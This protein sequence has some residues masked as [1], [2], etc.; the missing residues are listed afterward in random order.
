MARILT[1]TRSATEQE[2]SA[3][4]NKNVACDLLNWKICTINQNFFWN[5]FQKMENG[6]KKELTEEMSRCK[7]AHREIRGNPHAMAE[8]LKTLLFNCFF[9]DKTE[10]IFE[11][12]YGLKR[13]CE[14]S[15][16]IFILLKSTHLGVS[17][18]YLHNFKPFS[19]IFAL[20]M[21]E[22]LNCGCEEDWVNRIWKVLGDNEKICWWNPS[23]C[24]WRTE[25]G[26]LV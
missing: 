15:F 25:T 23:Q 17:E 21:F 12:K 18:T 22:C 19:I 8:N 9:R 7:K 11:L 13:F 1:P 4:K 26:N 14:K 10:W 6:M 5:I 20:Q 16:G 2:H 24:V 3:W